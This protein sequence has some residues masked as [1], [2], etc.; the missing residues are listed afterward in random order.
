[1]KTSHA[2]VSSPHS[3]RSSSSEAPS[4]DSRFLYYIN[5][6]LNIKHCVQRKIKKVKKRKNKEC[7]D[8]GE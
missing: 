8:I 7:Q 1:M 2:S 5:V 4:G 6:A 3:E